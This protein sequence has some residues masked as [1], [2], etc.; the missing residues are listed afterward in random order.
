MG[1]QGRRGDASSPHPPHHYHFLKQKIFFR[2]KLENIKFLHESNMWNF[3][4]FIEQ[5]I[6][7][8]K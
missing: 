5:D 8:K 1:G 2:V 4:F 3:S 6:S 7:D